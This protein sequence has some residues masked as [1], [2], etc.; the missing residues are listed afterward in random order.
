MVKKYFSLTLVICLIQII[1]ITSATA[2]PGASQDISQKV[3]EGIAKIG[4][5]KDTKVT[6]ERKN[7]AVVKGFVY[8]AGE[9]SFVVRDEVTDKSTDIS[10]S[11]VKK[12]EGKNITTGQK[13][14]I[15]KKI[16]LVAIITLA[17]VA[18]VVAIAVREA[19]KPS[20]EGIPGRVAFPP[21]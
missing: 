17:V 3:K 10:Y 16:T 19:T 18:V 7:K 21:D 8:E 20:K 14:S 13:M 4:T 9:K 2:R 11:D 5:G 12:I 1:T 6:V 15:G